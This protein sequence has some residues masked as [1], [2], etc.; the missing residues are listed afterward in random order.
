MP[1]Y[2]DFRGKNERVEVIASEFVD[3]NVRYCTPAK[4][5]GKVGTLV[6]YEDDSYNTARPTGYERSY[7]LIQFDDGTEEN[8]DAAFCRRLEKS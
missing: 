7:Y 8:V 2:I 1:A 6:E 3:G 5:V 4:L